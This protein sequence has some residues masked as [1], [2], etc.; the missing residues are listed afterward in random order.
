MYHQCLSIG[1][2]IIYSIVS[3]S[4]YV[5]VDL[6]V[7]LYQVHSVAYM[8]LCWDDISHRE[9]RCSASVET[10]IQMQARPTSTHGN[11]H[12]TVCSTTLVHTREH[13][14]GLVPVENDTTHNR[15]IS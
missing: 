4:I 10:N 13:V 7:N 1:T 14:H 15:K 5:H 2:L 3:G 6:H 8:Y 11:L 9:T 12:L